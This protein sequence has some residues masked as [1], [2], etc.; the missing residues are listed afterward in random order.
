MDAARGVRLGDGVVD[1]EFGHPKLAGMYDMLDAD[2]S[3][4][5]FYLDLVEELGA[6]RVL[7]VGCGTGTLALLLAD[8][9][10][11]VVGLDPALA[12]LEVARGKPGSERVMWVEGDARVLTV[13]DRDLV[14]MTANVVEPSR[15]QP[16]GRQRF[17]RSARHWPRTEPWCSRPAIRQLAHGRAGPGTSLSAP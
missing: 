2:R 7:D 16:P 6:R 10:C 15:T 14:T 12:S 4:L 13:V 8:R 11:D 17:E 9:G 1:E 5:V 3:D